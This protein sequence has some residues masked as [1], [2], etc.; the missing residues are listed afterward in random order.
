M[1]V[2]IDTREPDLHTECVKLACGVDVQDV[3]IESETLPI[4]DIIIYDDDG[5]ENIIIE[6]KTL[7]D[8]AA[9][10]RDGRYKEQSYRL[11][12]C[13]THNHNIF[14]LIEGN[15]KSYNPTKCRFEK[16]SLLSSLVTLTYFK[17]F[18]LHRTEDVCESAE[19]IIAYAKKLQKENRK[20][21]Y[22][23]TEKTPKSYVSVSSR[24]KKNNI[25]HDNIGAIMLAQIPSVS[26]AVACAV[27]ERF[28]NIKT[29]IDEMSQNPDLL[30]EVTIATQSNKPRKISK[31]SIQNIY[32]YLVVNSANEI[33]VST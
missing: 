12:G 7:N 16:G 10:I 13:E 30:N 25:T 22:E 11:D 32:N 21:Y 28:G 27:M 1:L 3:S 23:D 14:Y 20:S 29:L 18:S 17:G 24:V 31:T 4:G 26:T 5:V 33:T 8:L 19:W 9:S 2:K 6:R 15:L